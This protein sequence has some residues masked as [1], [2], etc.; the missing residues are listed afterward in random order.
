MN[1]TDEITSEP[2]VSSVNPA[3][4]VRQC[5]KCGQPIIT[6][7]VLRCPGC[8]EVIRLR[9]FTYRS[10]RSRQYVAECIDLDIAS[11]GTSEKE[12]IGG[13]QDAM[14]G[15]LA[16]AFDGSGIEGLIFRP[17]PT[18]H[19]L[20]YHLQHLSDRILALFS[21]RH[22]RRTAEEFYSVPTGISHIRC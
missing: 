14:R 10:W 21:A 18:L 11:E 1:S 6:A 9:C 4:Q 12:A 22:A 15:Y 5:Q 7:P 20:R 13:L 8:G 19:R 2:R 3:S 16:V 17:S